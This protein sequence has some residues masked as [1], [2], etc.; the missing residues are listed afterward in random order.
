MLS[1]E[2]TEAPIAVDALAAMVSSPVA[3]AVATF[4][5]VVRDHH[6]GKPV[7]SLAY[8]AYLPMAERELRAVATEAC[9]R[10][11]IEAIALHHRHGKLRIGDVA[12]AIAVSAAH[13]DA[14][15][16]ALR[17][18]IDMLKRRV[19]IWKR[20]TGPDGTFWIEGPDRVAAAD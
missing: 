5:G 7:A 18:T 15:F 11:A 8:E 20:E 9:E 16:D 17:F 2:I 4:A 1:I 3:G 10:F 12:V 6:D 13:R 19:P 14:A